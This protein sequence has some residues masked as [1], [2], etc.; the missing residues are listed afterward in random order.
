[1]A[2]LYS[3]YFKKDTY[4]TDYCNR[5]IRFVVTRF[6]FILY[7]WWV[8]SYFACYSRHHSIS[9]CHT[10]KETVDTITK[11]EIFFTKPCAYRENH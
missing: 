7:P 4:A 11:L 10:R 9:T 5:F 2:V 1:M 8:Y 6:S 3:H